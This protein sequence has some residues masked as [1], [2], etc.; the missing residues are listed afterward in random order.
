[1]FSDEFVV[2]YSYVNIC[3]QMTL[4][5]IIRTPFTLESF[6]EK[7]LFD[8]LVVMTIVEM[9]VGPFICHAQF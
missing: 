1:M 7:C 2:C 3:V 9:Y 8:W 5:L 4:V 6:G